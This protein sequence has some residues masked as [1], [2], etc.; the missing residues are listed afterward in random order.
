MDEDFKN[1]I[2]KIYEDHARFLALVES[3]PPLTEEQKEANRAKLFAQEEPLRE[4]KREELFRRALQ[5]DPHAKLYPQPEQIFPERSQMA[6]NL[7]L[8]FTII[9]IT[10]L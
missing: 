4:A 7:P 6:S 10:L 9:E 2:N 8:R 5:G 3:T 1:R